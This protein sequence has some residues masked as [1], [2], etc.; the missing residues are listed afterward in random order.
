MALGSNVGGG[1]VVVPVL[2]VVPVP[3]DV[4]DPVDVLVDVEAV[5]VAGFFEE[6][7][8]VLFDAPLVFVVVAWLVLPD[9]L[10]DDAP[11]V[12]GPLLFGA[13][14]PTL[15]PFDVG[16]LV[17]PRPCAAVVA[18]NAATTTAV[19][20]RSENLRI[21]GVPPRHQQ[22][23][24]DAHKGRLGKRSACNELAPGAR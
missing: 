2:A 1:V 13:P 8:D 17:A 6:P 12:D 7:C 9:L 19:V 4:L 20:A 18:V 5:V 14:V 11:C 21:C 23:K 16:A 22:V 24:I 15:G 3:V 10:P